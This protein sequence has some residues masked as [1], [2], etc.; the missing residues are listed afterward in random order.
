MSQ[1]TLTKFGIGYAPDSW[2]DLVNAMRKKGEDDGFDDEDE[3]NEVE[4]EH[5]E[6]I[7]IEAKYVA[8]KIKKLI[9]SKYQVY[10]RK[11][12]TFRDITYKDIAILLRSTK[13]KASIYEQELIKLDM[14]VFADSNQEYLDSIEIQTI[15]SL[16]KIIDNPMQDIPLVTV[17][18]S[19][20]GKFTDNELVEIRLSDKYDNFYNCMQ[21]AKVDVDAQLKEKIKTNGTIKVLKGNN[22][23]TDTNTFVGTGMQIQIETEKYIAIVK[24]DLNGDGKIGLSDLSN[25]KFSLIGKKQLSTEAQMAGDINGDGKVSLS[26]MVKL[27]MYLLGKVNI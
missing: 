20:I 13:D 23:I 10:D 15:M 19:N 7:E 8:N 22:E 11:K 12:E 4:L 17:L 6:N 9:D 2:D 5:L 1:T 18:R 21:K 16:L 26:D 27:K 25:I 14:P 3:E 24:A